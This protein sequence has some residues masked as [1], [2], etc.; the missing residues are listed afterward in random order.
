M[1]TSKAVGLVDEVTRLPDNYNTVLESDDINLSQG[2]KQKLAL[3]RCFYGN[4]KLVLLDNPTVALDPTTKVKLLNTL[5]SLK[6]SG[7][8]IIFISDDAS[9]QSL[10]DY[11][12]ELQEGTVVKG[13]SMNKNSSGS[14][15]VTDLKPAAQYQSITY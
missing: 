6:E 4:P 15:N 14:K 3:A 11:V 9:L 13:Y 7:T 8:T 10:A 5:I 2:Q 1:A 12:V